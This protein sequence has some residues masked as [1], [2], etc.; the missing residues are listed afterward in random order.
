MH[1]KVINKNMVPEIDNTGSTVTVILPYH[2]I[3]IT[4]N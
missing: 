1:A 3:T 4:L 2:C